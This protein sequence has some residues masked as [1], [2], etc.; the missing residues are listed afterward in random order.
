MSQNHLQKRKL[1]KA[2]IRQVTVARPAKPMME[3]RA[4]LKVNN[5]KVRINKLRLSYL[6]KITLWTQQTKGKS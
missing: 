6:A 1:K 2:K 4:V 3:L 5:L